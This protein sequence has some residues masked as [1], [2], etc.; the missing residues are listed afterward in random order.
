ML[1]DVNTHIYIIR[2]YSIHIHVYARYTPTG[3]IFNCKLSNYKHMHISYMMRCMLLI[4]II[5][6]SYSYLA[7]YV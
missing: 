2:N 6:D 4:T 1:S 5:T 7:K 3:K